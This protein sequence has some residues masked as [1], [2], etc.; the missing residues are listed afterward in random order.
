MSAA[1]LREAAALMR[2]RAEAVPAGPWEAGEAEP[3]TQAEHRALGMYSVVFN[4][5]KVICPIPGFS[6]D[7]KSTAEHIASWHPEVALAVARWL[8]DESYA[9]ETDLGDGIT[10]GGPRMEALAVARVYLG[11]D[12]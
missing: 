11:T 9:P 4:D 6:R 1:E 7:R 5:T 3:Q 12:P 10:T 8:E 2:A